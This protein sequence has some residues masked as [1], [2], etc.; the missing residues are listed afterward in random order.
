MWRRHCRRPRPPT[1][2]T[3]PLLGVDWNVCVTRRAD[4][5][6]ASIAVKQTNVRTFAAKFFCRFGCANLP[7]NRGCQVVRDRGKIFLA[8]DLRGVENVFSFE[9]SCAAPANSLRIR[10][11]NAAI[12]KRKSFAKRRV[13]LHNRE[14]RLQR[15]AKYSRKYAAAI[16][17]FK[18]RLCIHRKRWMI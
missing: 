15:I 16:P 6:R 9:Q 3:P 5:S 13:G 1:R 12:A 4:C 17:D 8:A 14:S 11:E 7:E 10:L 18:T 2:K